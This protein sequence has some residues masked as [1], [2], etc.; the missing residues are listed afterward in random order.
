MK[1]YE[2]GEYRATKGWPYAI[3]AGCVVYR[4]N[5]KVTE[6]LLLL[7]RAGEFPHFIDGNVDSYHLPKGHMGMNE[8][9]A[10]TAQRETEEEAGCRVLLQ[11]YLGARVHQYEDAGIKRDKIIHYFAG[12]WQEDVQGMDDEHSERVWVPLKEATK[13]VGG[14]NPKREDSIIDRLR[15]FL[16]M[17]DDL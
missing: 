4:T 12:E 7:R 3:G 10:Q 9:V 5:N 13:L 14:S 16:E 17:T 1:L 15:Q 2:S 8:T 11:T 6:V